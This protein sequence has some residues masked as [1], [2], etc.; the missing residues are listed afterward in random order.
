MSSLKKRF[1]TRIS[2]V[3]SQGDRG[4]S[5]PEVLIAIGLSGLLALGCTQLAM[6]S[7]TSANYTQDVAV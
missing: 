5:L 4:I 3:T 7:F 6:A 2:E 1:A